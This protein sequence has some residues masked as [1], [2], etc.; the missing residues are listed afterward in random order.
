MLS[1]QLLNESLSRFN[2]NFAAFLY[3]LEMNAFV[4]DWPE[5][6]V[7]ESWVRNVKRRGRAESSVN[8]GGGGGETGAKGKSGGASEFD[9]SLLSDTTF[10]SMRQTPKRRT[11]GQDIGAAGGAAE[12]AE[13]RDGR[14]RLGRRSG[15]PAR[16]GGYVSGAVRG[17]AGGRGRSA[18][19]GRGIPG[20]GRG[21]ARTSG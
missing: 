11:L 16:S 19:R 5:A 6:P 8:V 18:G 1:L 15:I 14:G 17:G 13:G 2:E 4:V 3:G 7:A 20:R 10:A 21:A 9:T 12:T